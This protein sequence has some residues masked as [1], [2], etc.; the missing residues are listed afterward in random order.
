MRC[1]KCGYE[2]VRRK[3]IKIREIHKDKDGYHKTRAYNSIPGY[4]CKK[5]GWEQHEKKV[6]F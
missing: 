4:K 6:L 5:C 3:G 2:Y 1:P